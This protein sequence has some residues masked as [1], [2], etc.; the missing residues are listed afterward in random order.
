MQ[1]SKKKEAGLI[2]GEFAF[3]NCDQIELR[4][5]QPHELFQ[6]LIVMQITVALVALGALT[7]DQAREVTRNFVID[8]GEKLICAPRTVIA[9]RLRAATYYG[10]PD[11]SDADVNKHVQ[12]AFSSFVEAALEFDARAD[13]LLPPIEGV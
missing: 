9:L 2:V 8:D 3:I 6:Q 10:W 1:L 11:L 5:R 7:P 12:T 4:T 13:I